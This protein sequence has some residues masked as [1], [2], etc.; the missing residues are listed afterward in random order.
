ML[1]WLWLAAS[2]ASWFRTHFWNKMQLCNKE[3]ATSGPFC[4]WRS[5]S[6]IQVQRLNKSIQQGWLM[7]PG[8]WL[9][10]MVSSLESK[11]HC[12]GRWLQY[13]WAA[14]PLG[15]FVIIDDWGSWPHAQL[16]VIDFL[17]QNGLATALPRLAKMMSRVNSSDQE[18]S[19]SMDMLLQ[20]YYMTSYLLVLDY[21]I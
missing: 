2:F 1:L 5:D 12:L 17:E 18:N 13:G 10:S 3:Y 14:T 21:M 20:H 6:I 8:I 19:E 16:A 11:Q 9:V 4:F 15:G 7:A